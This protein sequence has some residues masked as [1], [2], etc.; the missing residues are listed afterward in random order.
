MK[1]SLQTLKD[2]FLAG[3]LSKADYIEKMHEKHRQLYE[4][5][6]FMQDTDV[7]KIILSNRELI[8]ELG[9]QG[10]RLKCDPA[11]HRPAPLD[12]LNFG[13]YEKQE[14]NVLSFLAR[15]SEVFLDVGANLG[16]YS[17]SLTRQN[18]DLTAYAFE[19]IPKTYQLLVENLKLNSAQRVR[20]Q[21]LGLSDKTGELEFFYYPEGAVNASLANVSG[22]DDVE[23]LRCPVKTLDQFCDEQNLSA[24]DLIKVDV[25]GAE[26]FTL[27]GAGKTL[28]KFKPA[29]FAEMLRKWA[30]PF[31][32]HPNEIIELM[33]KKGYH[34]YALGK[35]R[36][37][38]FD[39]MDEET[40]ETNF[41]FLH[42]ERHG[43]QVLNGLQ[44]L[45]E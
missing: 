42:P 7:K 32:Y 19:P 45:F 3:K 44:N 13:E 10:I 24:V 35:N 31:G 39:K 41:L 23:V 33:R 14:F 20:P 22:R 4:Y 16:W 5:M 2:Q 6:E 8:F 25:E 34:C 40:I 38:A 1:N 27:R 21:A 30:A 15:S 17:L 26:L 29:V 12:A 18:P 11:D 9:D 37:S 36:L 28:E 43:D